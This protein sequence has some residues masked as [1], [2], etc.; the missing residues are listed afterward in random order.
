MINT[1]QKKNK[2]KIYCIDI[3]NDNYEKIKKLNYIPVGLGKDNFNKNWVR[4][5]SGDNITNKNPFY[6]EYTF[7]YWFWKNKL[8]EINDNEWIG[9]CAY[10]RFW[11]SRKDCDNIKELDDF[12]SEIPAEWKNYKVIIGQNIYLNW[13]FSK[14]IKHGL[15]SFI[16]NP[17]YIFKKNRN[18]KLHFDSFHGYGNLDKAIELLTDEDR[19]DFRKFTTTRNYYNRS[20]MFFCSSKEIMESYYKAVFAWMFKCEKVFGFNNESYGLKRIYGFLIER[21]QSYWFQKYTK[22]L[23]WPIILHDINKSEL[24]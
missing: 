15:K 8:K 9:F 5:N 7:H 19:E 13:K 21:F 24:L 4:D 6:G 20:S 14:F 2:M 16:L 12:F 1:Y 3:N 18:I 17:S 11:A 22:P 23:V 10:R